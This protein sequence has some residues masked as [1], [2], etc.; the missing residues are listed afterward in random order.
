VRDGLLLDGDG[1]RE[2]FYLI[3]VGTLDAADEL[4]RVCRERFDE[5]AL[6]LCVNGIE[7]ERRFARTRYTRYYGELVARYLNVDVLEVVLARTLN[8]Y[9]I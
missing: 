6:A 2:P 5:T 9:F 4:A 3:N 8:Y 1:R 7:G